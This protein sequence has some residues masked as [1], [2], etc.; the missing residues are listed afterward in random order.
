VGHEGGIVA[1]SNTLVLIV[2]DDEN[3]A[4]LVAEMLR[5]AGSD[6]VH[7][8]DANGAVEWLKSHKPELILTDIGLP[9]I[10]GVQLCDILKAGAATAEIPIIVISGRGSEAHKVEA[11]RAGVDDYLVKPFSGRELLARIEALLRRTR[12]GGR[13]GRLLASGG[14]VLDLDSRRATIAGARLRLLP[15]EYDLLALFLKRKECVLPFFEI[16]EAVWGCDAFAARTTIKA[17]AHR[18][19]SKLGGYAACIEPVPGLGYMWTDKE[20]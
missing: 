5:G 6:T 7:F 18:L 10:S 17:T 15:K 19:R 16:A 14:L 20:V 1:T 11:L 3:L 12:Y 2:E 9:G 4:G 13:T 8:P